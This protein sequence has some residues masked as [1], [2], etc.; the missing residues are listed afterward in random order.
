MMSTH[1]VAF[2]SKRSNFAPKLKMPILLKSK[3]RHSNY[4]IEPS[5]TIFQPLRREL[6]AFKKKGP[7][8]TSFQIIIKKEKK[9]EIS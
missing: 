9:I 2:Y 3:N 6:L 7:E 5:W 1:I 4:S 8:K